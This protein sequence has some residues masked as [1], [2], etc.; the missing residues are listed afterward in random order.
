MVLAVLNKTYST[1]STPYI[2]WNFERTTKRQV[3]A[4]HSFITRIPKPVNDNN[5]QVLWDIW[6][7]ST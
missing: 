5:K 4:L 1:I 6:G 2:N 3:L 7:N